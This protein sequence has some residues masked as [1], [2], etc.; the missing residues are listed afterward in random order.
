MKVTLIFGGF[1]VLMMALMFWAYFAALIAPIRL[2]A[3]DEA[4]K[5]CRR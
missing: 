5:A 1:F 4:K 3:S 2:L